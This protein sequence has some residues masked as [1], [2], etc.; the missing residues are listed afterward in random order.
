MI[1][2]TSWGWWEDEERS[3]W[4]MLSTEPVSGSAADLRGVTVTGCVVFTGVN[5]EGRKGLSGRPG[6]AVPRIATRWHRGAVLESTRRR[7]PPT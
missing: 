6:S 3:T 1:G 7:S 5:L 4:I 2:P